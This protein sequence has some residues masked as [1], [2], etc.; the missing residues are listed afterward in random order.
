MTKRHPTTWILVCD[1][2]R[3]RIFSH[4]S[5][6]K[7]LTVVTRAGN[8][9]A[10]RRTRELGSDRP[11]RTHE[12]THTGQRHAMEPRVDWHRFEKARFAQEMAAVLDRAALDGAMDRLVLVAPPQV[13]GDLR[14]ALGAHGKGKLAGEINKDLTNLEAAELVIQLDE[15]INR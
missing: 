10:H 14:Q 12:S 9:E 7:G 1:G 6:T 4:E 11:G 15:W 8:A 5:G 13:L 3:G 2:A